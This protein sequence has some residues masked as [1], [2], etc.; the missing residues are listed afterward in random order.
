VVTTIPAVCLSCRA[1]LDLTLEYTHTNIAK[2][3]V[4]KCPV[5]QQSTPVHAAGTI[6]RVIERGVLQ[7]RT[8]S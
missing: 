1:S 2:W 8:A 6:V 3:M 4:C 7:K 5:C